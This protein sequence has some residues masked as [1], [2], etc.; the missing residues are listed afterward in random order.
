M[1]K[2]DLHLIET[3]FYCVRFSDHPHK[4]ETL[5]LS[6]LSHKK[7]MNEFIDLYSTKIKGVNSDVVATY[8]CSAYG[9]FLSSLQ[10]IMSVFDTTY[11]TLLAN[12][13]LQ[14][15]F[16]EDEKYYGICFRIVDQ[17]EIFLTGFREGWRSTTLEQLY[18]KNVVPLVELLH[19]ATSVRKRELYGQLAIG[20]YNGHDL[21]M[22]LAKSKEQKEIVQKDFSFLTKEL[23]N[24]L[25]GMPKNPLDISFKLIESPREKGVMIKLKP[26]C[27]LYYQTEGATTK[28]YDC[29][30][31]SE[32]ERAE[33]K[34]RILASM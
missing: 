1:T 27:C 30:R 29:P 16:D 17:K 24:H 12:I 8:F 5:L 13:E 32:E 10:Y 22:K 23:G 2:V 21:N 6:E 18:A 33:R 31:M 4:L 28:C 11:N 25:F 19:Q 20:L 26:S 14:I 15:Y 34:K 9:W 3:E 7:I